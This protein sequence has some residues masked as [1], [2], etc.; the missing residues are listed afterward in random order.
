MRWQRGLVPFFGEQ[1]ELRQARAV[2]GPL[3]SFFADGEDCRNQR[4]PRPAA[5]RLAG[6]TSPT[7]DA[8]A[9]VAAIISL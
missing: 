2:P 7:I 6:G 8:I 5:R 9:L 3:P 1:A 4:R